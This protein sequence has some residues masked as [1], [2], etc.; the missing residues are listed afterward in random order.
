M[1]IRQGV[2]VP[3][4]ESPRAIS[5][6]REKNRWS[7]FFQHERDANHT[8]TLEHKELSHSISQNKGR[9]RT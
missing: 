6:A 8:D 4:H 5:I 7:P 2:P 3:D 9:A 1:S